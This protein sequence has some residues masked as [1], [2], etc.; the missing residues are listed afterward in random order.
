MA[1]TRQLFCVKLLQGEIEQIGPNPI[2]RGKI[3]ES[4]L[5]A[6]SDKKGIHELVVFL[7][8]LTT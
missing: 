6:G 7:P 4:G 8:I 1:I 3:G 2:D 5:C